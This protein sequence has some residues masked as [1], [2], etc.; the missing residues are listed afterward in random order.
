MFWLYLSAS[1]GNFLSIF[2]I[3]TIIA[4]LFI[5]YIFCFLLS[6]IF[7]YIYHFYFFY[8]LLLL[9]LLLLFIFHFKHIADFTASYGLVRD[10]AKGLQLS[11]LS[12]DGPTATCSLCPVG[13]LPILWSRLRSKLLRA[14]FLVYSTVIAYLHKTDYRYFY[15][16][17]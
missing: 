11:L 15:R 3:V 8:L 10:S 1:G 14:L 4:F 17:R 13:V 7:F 9:L 12:F 2:L 16:C 6:F 5:F